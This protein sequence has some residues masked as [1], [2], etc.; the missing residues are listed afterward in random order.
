MRRTGLGIT[1]HDLLALGRL[2]PH[3]PAEDFNM[4]Y[5]AIRGS[6]AVNG[7]SRLHGEVSRHLFQP[8]FPRWPEAEVPVG[9]V[10]NGVHMPSWDSAHADAL[11]TQAAGKNRWLGTTETLEQDIRKISDAELWRCRNASRAITG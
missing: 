5:L 3:D 2:N 1:L 7:V 6:G 9:H 10:T 4:A 11:W 8:L